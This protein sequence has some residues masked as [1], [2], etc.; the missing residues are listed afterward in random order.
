MIAQR[1]REGG[2]SCVHTIVREGIF[3]GFRND[4]LERLSKAE[5]NIEILLKER[6]DQRV[7]LLA[8]RLANRVEAL[9]Q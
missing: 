1:H 2:R 8:G 3:A 9:K 7:N 6:P 4:N 5:Q